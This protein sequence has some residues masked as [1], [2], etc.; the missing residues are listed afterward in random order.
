MARIFSSLQDLVGNTPL[1]R[2]ERLEQALGLKAQLVAKLESFNPLSSVKDRAALGMIEAGERAGILTSESVIIEA[3]SGNTGIALSYLARL[4]GYRCIIVMPE[5]MSIERRSL[6]RALG[7]EL[8]LSPGSEGMKGAL[9]VAE[10]LR[11]T[12]AEA[13]SLSQFDHPANP[14]KHAETTAQEIWRDT[15]GIVD[16]VVAGVGTGGTI[17][18]IARG[19]RPHIP[20]VKIIAVEPT[21]SPVLSGGTPGPHTIQG[22]GAGFIPANYDGSLI[23]EVLQATHDEALTTARLVARTEAILT[24]FS[25]GAALSVAIS[26]AQR[27]E[28]EGKTIVVILPDTGERYLS[29]PLF[30]IDE[31]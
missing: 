24:G 26:I 28:A 4:R 6:I 9:R 22:I 25:G 20:E 27:A 23:D 1:V 14:A 2:L 30:R 7:S 15:D 10:E 18:G 12:T 29:T 19:L 8:V 16:Y 21:A 13:V 31:A 3:S 11:A 5:T 17:T